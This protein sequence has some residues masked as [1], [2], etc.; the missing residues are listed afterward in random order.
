MFIFKLVRVASSRL[1][2][3]SGSGNIN[4]NK[5]KDGGGGRRKAYDEKLF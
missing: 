5:K 1:N 4:N 2:R 3:N